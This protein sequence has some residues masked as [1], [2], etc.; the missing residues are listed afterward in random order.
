MDSLERVH[1]G[2]WRLREAINRLEADLKGPH[3]RPRDPSIAQA[4]HDC[5]MRLTRLAMWDTAEP[6][7]PHLKKPE[8][9][10]RKW[11]WA[12]GRQIGIATTPDDIFWTMNK[13]LELLEQFFKQGYPIEDLEIMFQC[14]PVKPQLRKLG[15]LPAEDTLK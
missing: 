6:E 9:E 10:N 2:I 1:H 15:L 12:F 14:R 7:W 5:I 13:R 8:D 3:G 11:F 4:D